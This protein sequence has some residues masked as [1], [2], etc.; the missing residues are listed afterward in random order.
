[1]FDLREYKT[2]DLKNAIILK[3]D[4]AYKI[5]DEITG[6]HLVVKLM[7]IL[8]DAES[9]LVV[10]FR[11]LAL[12]STESEFGTIGYLAECLLDGERH[13]CYVMDFIEGQTLASF[14]S[15]SDFVDIEIAFEIIRQLA[16]GLEKAHAAEIFHSDLHDE[17]VFID[18]FFNVKIIDPHW[19]ELNI[20]AKE[21]QLRDLNSFRKL[22]SQIETKIDPSQ[23]N[24]FGL[25]NK[26]CNATQSFSGL[27]RALEA[28]HI[29]S[30]EITLIS[31]Q[32]L[33]ILSVIKQ[34]IVK[35]YKLNMALV[36]KD[37]PIPKH[38]LSEITEDEKSY[39]EKLR[40]TKKGFSNFWILEHQELKITCKKLLFLDFMNSKWQDYVI[41]R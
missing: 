34:Q 36:V 2:I 4:K 29:I 7:D 15:S 14:L 33:E 40:K 8:G 20:D 35:D 16:S 12:L 3:K 25:L 21:K 23:I 39:V 37:I 9:E 32:G 17:N 10:E 5:K 41:S 13:S 19:R 18:R 28:I 26:F 24:R 27:K 38:L 31:D 11:K 1:M 30:D 22:I 6:K